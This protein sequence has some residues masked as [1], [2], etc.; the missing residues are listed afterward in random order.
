AGGRRPRDHGGEI[1]MNAHN[2][3][4]NAHNPM[5]EL[6]QAATSGG[7]SLTAFGVMAIILGVLALLAPGVTALSLSILLGLFVTA[8][9]I[10][11]MLWAFQGSSPGKGLLTFALGT[12]TLVCGIV[13]LANPVIGS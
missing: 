8:G 11:R 3:V 10:L 6:A 2:P 13:L 1:V 7:R 5:G 4:M 12:L 9:G